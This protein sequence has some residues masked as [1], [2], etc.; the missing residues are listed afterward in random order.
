MPR[1]TSGATPPRATARARGYASLRLEYRA[2]RSPSRAVARR[3]RERSKKQKGERAARARRRSAGR[4]RF[5]VNLDPLA[6][7]SCSQAL[8]SPADRAFGSAGA[9][10]HVNDERWESK[11]RRANSQASSLRHLRRVRQDGFEFRKQQ[12][13]LTT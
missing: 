12:V 6:W 2:L 3:E 5:S 1:G 7:L 13:G 9:I 11:E 8:S 4:E 10:E